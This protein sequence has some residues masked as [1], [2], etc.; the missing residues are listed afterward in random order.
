MEDYQAYRDAHLTDMT[1]PGDNVGWVP[2]NEWID[3][4]EMHRASKLTVDYRN[5]EGILPE[6]Y[7]RRSAGFPGTAEN[8]EAFSASS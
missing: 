1:K 7:P 3:R 4:F 5:L 6:A 8:K 2:W